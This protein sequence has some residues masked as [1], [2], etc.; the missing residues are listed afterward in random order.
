[1]KRISDK[2]YRWIVAAVC[3]LTVMIGLGFCAMKNIYLKTVSESL[4]ISR[5]AFAVTEIIRYI[6]TAGMNLFFGTLVVKLRPKRMILIGAV[7]LFCAPLC[8]AF[9]Q[10]VALLYLGGFFLG[11]GLAWST[12][13]M[14]GYV[15]GKWFPKNR[16]TIM[17]IVLASSGLGAALCTRLLRPIVIGEATVFGSTGWRL[18]YFLTAMLVIPLFLLLL[19]FFRGEPT[20]IEET[21]A[22]GKKRRGRSWEGMEWEQIRKKPYFYFAAVCVFFVG[23]CLQSAN[24]ISVAHLEDVGLESGYIT[25]I[26]SYG[27]VLLCVSKTLSGFS[28]DKLGLRATLIICLACGTGASLLLALVTPEL[29][30]LA[31]VFEMLIPFALPME[32]VMLPLIAADMFGEKCFPKVMGLFV[33]INTAG[34]AAGAL[35][36]NAVFDIIGSY[37]VALFAFTGIL[38]VITISEQICLSLAARDREALEAA[39]NNA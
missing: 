25:K 34:Y 16:G 31:L 27:M 15:V 37:R 17:G 33:S 28:Y 30:G 13:T 14:V 35:L 3:F 20:H 24:G 39:K 38:L 19:A 5:S 29:P 1:M 6:T 12:T 23:L 9:A 36:S 2:K 32:T 10:N 11:W 22:P 21:A 18:G 7:C 8:Y 26:A 4:Q